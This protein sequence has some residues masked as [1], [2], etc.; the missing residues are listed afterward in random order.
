MLVQFKLQKAPKRHRHIVSHFLETLSNS[1]K[2][3][4][5][6]SLTIYRG[7]YMIDG[8]QLHMHASHIERIPMV[9]TVA[10]L[11]NQCSSLW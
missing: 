5:W 11:C 10:T 7:V 6:P 3:K 8:A 2:L 4:P 1:K 9:D